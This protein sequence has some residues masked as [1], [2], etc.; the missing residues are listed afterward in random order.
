MN[1]WMEIAFDEALEGMER[2]EGGPFGAVIVRD[3][4]VI[5]RTH[6][7]V[8]KTND[9]TAHAEILAI[10]EASRKL[11]TFDL[12]GCVLYTSCYPCPM[13]M[14]AVLWARI[15]TVYY[16][17]SMDDAAKGGFDDRQFYAMIQNPQ[18]ALDLQPVDAEGGKAL[19]NA[20]NAK[21]DRR[22]Y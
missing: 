10:R 18:A 15:P 5:A 13:C 1:M 3:G 12:S 2:N 6:N 22:L 19:F 4:E 8:L 16:A 21:E 9:P 7:E 11:G 20:W 14:G 17:S